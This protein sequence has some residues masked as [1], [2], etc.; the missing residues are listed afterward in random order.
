[1]QKKIKDFFYSFLLFCFAF[2]SISI[3]ASEFKD[4]EIRIIRPRFFNKTGKFELGLQ[5]SAITDQTFVYTYMMSGSISYNLNEVFGLEVNAGYGISIDKEDKDLLDQGF[6]IMTVIHRTESSFQSYLTWNPM[7]G[8]YQL[9][10]GRLIYFDTFLALGGGFTGILYEYDHCKL[11]IESQSVFLQQNQSFLYP[12]ISY[13]VGQ[14]FY[15]DKKSSLRWDLR[16]TYFNVDVGHAACDGVT[17]EG[18]TVAL[19]NTILQIG[20]SIFL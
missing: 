18:D 19:K 6:D 5:T 1:M 8:K 4:F 16:Q 20:Y 15:L 14:R 7:Y 9:E 10:S 11:K 13:G 2:N 3:F 12:S 17:T